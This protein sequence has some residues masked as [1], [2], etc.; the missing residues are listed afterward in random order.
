V[1][2]WQYRWPTDHS[3]RC[4]YNPSCTGPP[5]TASYTSLI[6]SR[7]RRLCRS[8]LREGSWCPTDIVLDVGRQSNMDGFSY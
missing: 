4:E 5:P 8:P 1:D 6:A 3:L 2:A 7:P